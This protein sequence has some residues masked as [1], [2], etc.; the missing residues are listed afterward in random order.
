[1]F[2][3][4]TRRFAE[5][6][7]DIPF[8]DVNCAWIMPQIGGIPQIQVEGSEVYVTTFGLDA[9]VQWQMDVARQGRFQVGQRA[10]KLLSNKIIE[11]K[12]SKVTSEYAKNKFIKYL[13]EEDRADV[14]MNV[15][16]DKKSLVDVLDNNEPVLFDNINFGTYFSDDEEWSR[17]SL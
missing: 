13:P 1:M 17:F 8:D 5:A 3:S 16:F 15:M 6:R 11:E 12:L 9:A 4:P 7:Y 14:K 2:S 10:T